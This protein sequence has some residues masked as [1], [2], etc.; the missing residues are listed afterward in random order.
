MP[1]P[2]YSV[3]VYCVLVLLGST[4]SQEMCD[5]CAL[6]LQNRATAIKLFFKETWLPEVPAF[7][8]AQI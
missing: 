8:L 5:Y 6:T 4:L 1:A 3:G 2:C 7:H